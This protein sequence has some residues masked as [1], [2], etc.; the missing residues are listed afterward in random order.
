VPGSK[1]TRK[2]TIWEPASFATQREWRPRL[3][4]QGLWVGDIE[5]QADVE[6]A[7]NAVGE[8]TQTFS[9]IS[10][11]WPG[12]RNGQSTVPAQAANDARAMQASRYAT[13]LDDSILALAREVWE[14]EQE[15]VF[16]G[17]SRGWDDM[18][19]FNVLLPLLAATGP[20][21]LRSIINASL[22]R[23]MAADAEI[24]TQLSEN[25]ANNNFQ[26]G[27]YMQEFTDE[28]GVSPPSEELMSIVQSVK[29]YCRPPGA[30]TAATVA[31]AKNVDG[32]RGKKT[33]S[34]AQ[35]RSGDAKYISRDGIRSDTRVQK[36]LDF[37]R[38]LEIRLDRRGAYGALWKHPLD[39]AI[40][41]VG[42]ARAPVTRL[43]QHRQHSSSNYIMNLC[44]ATGFVLFG[45]K[46]DMRQYVIFPI[47][48]QYQAC[49]G[50]K[51]FTKLAQGYTIGGTGFSHELAGRS[52]CTVWDIDPTTWDT[53]IK[54]AL[55][56]IDIRRVMVDERIK[57]SQRQRI[58]EARRKLPELRREQRLHESEADETG[59]STTV[60]YGH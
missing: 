12:R 3:D 60:A 46:Y 7:A 22:G 32:V 56:R 13:A 51:I 5:D 6:T 39:A 29:A 52:I 19:Y 41:E 57:T 36:I 44:S 17:Q 11:M 40:V 55:E 1:S 25:L 59:P 53:F 54:Q 37:C 9:T 58:E 50:E 38:N 28:N 33:S 24:R 34:D 47:F 49:I 30:M 23:D 43:Q 26:P 31:T 27:I 8:P 2:S 21:V 20:K 48:N 4:S 10:L 16:L 35:I 18:V 15:E 42:Y 45:K 14:T